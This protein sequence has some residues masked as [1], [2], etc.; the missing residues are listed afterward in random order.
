[1]CNADTGVLGQVWYN[2]GSPKAFPDFNTKHTCKN[3]DDIR[4]W[5]ESHQV[6]LAFMVSSAK[7]E[8]D[9]RDRKG[10][11]TRRTPR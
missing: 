10:S 9:E 11:I 3:Y 6:R 1:M 7:L 2:K 4:A 8:A 5:G